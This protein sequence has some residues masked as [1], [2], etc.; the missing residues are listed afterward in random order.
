MSETYGYDREAIS[1]R[2]IVRYPSWVEAL[3][4]FLLFA[5]AAV[6]IC[7]G[8]YDIGN[9]YQYLY[10]SIGF[11]LMPC[12]STVLR[13]HLHSLI[14]FILV[15]LVQA[16]WLLLSPDLVLTTLGI[17][18]WLALTVYGAVRQVS[19]ENEREASMMVLLFSMVAMICIYILSVS[20]E[21]EGYETLLIVQA[22]IYAALFMYYEHWIGVHDALRNID[23]EG[24]FSLRRMLRF[25]NQMLYGYFGIAAAVFLVL[26]LLG[27]GDML[28]LLGQKSLLMLRRMLRYF[29]SI[30][31]TQ[32]TLEEEAV[33]EETINESYAQMFGTMESGVIWLILE[34]LLEIIFVLL[35]LGAIA[36]MI[37]F[38]VRKVGEGS[39]YQEPNYEETKVFYKEAAKPKTRRRSFKEIFDNS[40]ENKIRKLY[41]KKVKGQMGKKVQPYETPH[42]VGEVL[43]DIKALVHQ[44]DEA[45]YA[46][47]NI[48]D[49]DR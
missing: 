40:P 9:G 46:V 30:E 32:E 42:E 10:F 31:P 34:K 16:A 35:V 26:Y 11:F 43:P 48:K 28:G 2:K 21:R 7:Y 33:Q 19:K 47:Q 38:L 23:K 15:Q 41:Y 5:P 27:L 45:R 20:R 8:A 4:V 44:Y 18:Y 1:Y 22:F 13:R 25:N 49:S 12:L 6:L 3:K 14:L 24:N 37:Y 17:V 29:G 36:A 39:R